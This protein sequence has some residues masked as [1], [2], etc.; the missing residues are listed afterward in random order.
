MISVEPFKTTVTLP[1]LQSCVY[2]HQHH[3]TA[4]RMEL[5]RG[6][7]LGVPFSKLASTL[8]SGGASNESHQ[9]GMVRRQDTTRVAS[10][11]IDVLIL[12]ENPQCI[13]HE[14]E[15]ES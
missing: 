9:F 14:L 11:D 13:L 1:K 6:S 8:S 3:R 7:L 15:C 12:R 10:H 4:R 5:W 2:H